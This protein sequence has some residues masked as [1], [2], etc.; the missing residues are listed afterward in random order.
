MPLVFDQKEIKRDLMDF[1]IPEG[2]K[3]MSLG[4]MRL[5]SVTFPSNAEKMDWMMFRYQEYLEE[6]HVAEE[7]PKYS[8]QDGV[9]FNKEKTILIYCPKNKTGFYQVPDSVERIGTRAFESSKLTEIKLPENL[10]I[11]EKQ[12]FIY[13]ELEKINL[14]N[15]V[16]TIGNRA[17]INCWNLKEITLPENLEFM[18]KYLF[19]GCLGLQRIDISEENRWFSC[20]DGVLL[21][22]DKTELI[23]YPDGKSGKYEIP[24]GVLVV[25][26]SA[27]YGCNKIT[28]LTI[29]ESL[30]KAENNSFADSCVD[31]IHIGKITLKNLMLPL[32]QIINILVNKKFNFYYRE[33]DDIRIRI[34][35]EM[36]E[37]NAD[38]AAEKYIHNI[39]TEEIYSL[40]RM[41]DV[42]LIKT[43]LAHDLIKRRKLK[44]FISY[45]VSEKKPEIT[46]ILL[47]Y[48]KEKFGFEEEEQSLDL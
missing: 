9:L 20:A 1:H 4:G 15:T 12:A 19:N 46:S 13:S 31:I 45:S 18:G 26:D 29:P 21:N 40:I 28:E 24:E 35:L 43:L 14:P 22:K 38:P 27:F 39:S 41:D 47:N 37:K 6:I 5:R 23:K 32:Y 34:I 30:K 42:E 25:K 11:I 8:S 48:K 3:C 10:K 44:L 36:Y 7:N 17:F 16:T 2:T 33:A